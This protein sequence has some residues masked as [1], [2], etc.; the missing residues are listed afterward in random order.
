[1][2][3]TYRHVYTYEGTTPMSRITKSDTYDRLKD[4]PEL[5]ANQSMSSSSM[6]EPLCMD[7]SFGKYTTYI[8]N[9]MCFPLNDEHAISVIKGI[10]AERSTPDS[11]ARLDADKQACIEFIQRNEFGDFQHGIL[12]VEVEER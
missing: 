7:M 9:Q 11:R 8:E 2:A 4:V 5:D 12:R 10:Y 1:M 3:K 6:K